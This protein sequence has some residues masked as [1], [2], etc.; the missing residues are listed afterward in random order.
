LGDPADASAAGVERLP[1]LRGS[2]TFVH[3]AA[4]VGE[5]LASRSSPLRLDLARSR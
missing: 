3:P 2:T 1:I 4:A 5:R